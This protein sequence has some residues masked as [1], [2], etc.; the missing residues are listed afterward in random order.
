MKYPELPYLQVLIAFHEAKNLVQAAE[1]L[2]ISQPAVT[3]RLQRLQEQV[4]QPLY[5]FEGRKKVLT[6]YGKALYDLA[7]RNFFQIETDFQNLNRLYASPEQLVLRVGGQKEL[8]TLFSELI[9]FSGRID[10]RNLT[11][12]D[13]Y[14]ALKIDAI[15][16]ALGS[17]IHD[18][19]EVMSRKFFEGPCH[20]IFNRKFFTNVES[21]R[22]LVLDSKQLL[23]TPCAIHRSET[24]LI[25]K[26]CHGAKINSA[27][28]NKKAIFEDWYS[29]LSHIENGGGYAIVPGFL[30]SQ[31]K[32]LRVL[33]IPHSII[34]RTTYYAIFQRKLRKMDS[35]KSVLNFAVSSS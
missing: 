2:K 29:I 4:G 9:D 30:Q 18:T 15:D 25:E 34:P 8:L 21:F 23:T 35:F 13:A 7:K 5:A 12:K 33:D 32:N 1:N 19:A 20:V 31:S 17:A 16:L 24:N 22:D 14:E 11:D 6:H 26:F 3:Q 28:L 10:H 27:N